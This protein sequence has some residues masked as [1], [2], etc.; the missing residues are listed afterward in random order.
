MCMEDI[1]IG[2][3]MN[4]V[5]KNVAV[6]ANTVTT[7][8][9]AD[10]KRVA[11]LIGC[12]SDTPSTIAPRPLTPALKTGIVLPQNNLPILLRIED[13]GPVI[14]QEWRIWCPGVSDNIT[15]IDSQISDQ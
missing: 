4:S 2:R 7:L 13:I 3:K 1:R 12:G 10:P 15:V 6:A 5:A 8:V 11:L 14:T 9:G